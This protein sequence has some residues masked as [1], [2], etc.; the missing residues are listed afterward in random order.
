MGLSLAEFV[1]GHPGCLGD[2]SSL[3]E[4]WA[5]DGSELECDGHDEKIE[6]GRNSVLYLYRYLRPE[7]L[8]VYVAHDRLNGIHFLVALTARHEVVV[9]VGL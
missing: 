3:L 6:V 1:G 4:N 9:D 2:E 7:R 5:C 8:P